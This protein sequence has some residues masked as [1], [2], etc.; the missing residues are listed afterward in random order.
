MSVTVTGK[1]YVDAV[2]DEAVHILKSLCHK[3]KM[4]GREEGT[5]WS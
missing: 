2:R 1:S 3:S 4:H 5:V